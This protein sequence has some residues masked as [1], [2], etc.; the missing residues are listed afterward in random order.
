LLALVSEY[1]S[2]NLNNLMIDLVQRIK[3]SSIA[4][5]VAGSTLGRYTICL[6]LLLDQDTYIASRPFP[7]GEGTDH[8]LPLATIL[9]Q[10]FRFFHCHQITHTRSPVSGT[11]DL[12]FL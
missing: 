7:F 9:T 8:C 4:Q 1:C 10:T 5:K 11:L 12:A 6:F 2:H 3:Y